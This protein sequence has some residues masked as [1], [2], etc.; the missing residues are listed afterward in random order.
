MRNFSLYALTSV[1]ALGSTSLIACGDDED[2]TGT[3]P[4]TATG[5]PG[6]S[7]SVL[8]GAVDS[9]I[10][11]TAADSPWLLEGIVKVEDGATLTIEAGTVIQGD[12][13]TLGTLVVQ[14]GGQINA[15]GT[16]D[17]PIVFTSERPEDVA[18][19]G[20]WGGVIILGNAPIMNAD[21]NAGM[22]EATIEGLTMDELYG[23]DDPADSSGNLSYVRIEFS[24]VDLGDGNE[25]NGL[26]LGGVGSGTTISH[27]MVRNTLDDGFEW[28]G[29]TVNGDH[30]IV[31]G[32]GDD[33]FDMDQGYQGTVQFLY[34]KSNNPTTDDPHGFEMDSILDNTVTEQDT[35][36]TIWNTTLCGSAGAANPRNG[37]RL[38]ENFRGTIS[39]AL[40]LGFD[41]GLRVDNGDDM[42]PDN[43]DPVINNSLF[44]GNT[45]LGQDNGEAEI[46]A[47]TGNITDVDPM[48]NC[49]ADPPIPAANVEGGATPSGAGVDTSATYIGAFAAG[50][51]WANATEGGWVRY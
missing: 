47:G 20:D 40:V 14:R 33:A 49:D 42:E 17:N 19:A 2:D 5:G 4:T 45:T 23:G 50:D 46:M 30:L 34:A 22:A 35:A 16:A 32:C 26:T 27:V 7:S 41:I 25:I 44:F 3:T 38:R 28:F 21:G 36:P 6:T 31:F 43:A 37:M 8:S 51:T 11:L 48:V 15:V 1:L 29:G 13:E 10:T 9:D 18:A 24:G 12:A 39:N